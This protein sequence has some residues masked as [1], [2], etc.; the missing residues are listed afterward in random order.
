MKSL[1]MLDV[2]RPPSGMEKFTAGNLWAETSEVDMFAADTSVAAMFEADTS[3]AT[4]FCPIDAASPLASRL[5]G[6]VS[7]CDSP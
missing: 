7:P 3:C 1:G 5:R 4:A 6:A 2:T